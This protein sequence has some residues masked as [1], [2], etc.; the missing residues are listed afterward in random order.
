MLEA[1]RISSPSGR[2]TQPTRERRCVYQREKGRGNYRRC[3]PPIQTPASTPNDRE[4]TSRILPTPSGRKTQSTRGRRGGGHYR[5]CSPPIRRSAVR[6]G[7][8]PPPL[9]SAPRPR[10]FAV[11]HGKEEIKK[12]TVPRSRTR[13]RSS[14]GHKKLGRPNMTRPI[15]SQAFPSPIHLSR[16]AKLR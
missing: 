13:T 9:S 4:Q 8:S 7:A 5:R 11:R 6:G 12:A 15:Q 2:K 10:W 3:S 14:K 16:E 1:N